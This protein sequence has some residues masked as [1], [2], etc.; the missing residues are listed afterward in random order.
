MS[1]ADI[2]D[3]TSQ[4]ISYQTIAAIMG[5]YLIVVLI[6]AI[7]WI[8]ANWKIF[9]KMGEAGWKSIIPIYNEYILFKR[10]WNTKMFWI[11]L[12]IGVLGGIV[13]AAVDNTAGSIIGGVCTIV[14][15]V[16]FIMQLYYQSKSF[17]HG[18]GFTV[19]LVLL[20]TIFVLI[21]GF[22]K[23]EYQGNLSEKNNM[24]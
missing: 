2:A 24:I 4:G 12:A 21:L 9:T 17:G 16:I 15:F 1:N 3:L 14:T 19:G 11:S 10:T 18:G 22:G 5:T 20:N 13:D 7:I 6:I 8:V 23:S